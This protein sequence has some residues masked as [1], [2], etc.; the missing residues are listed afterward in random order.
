VKGTPKKARE[1][2]PAA[3]S[4]EKSKAAPLVGLASSISLLFFL[5]VCI[6][7]EPVDSISVPEPTEQKKK[8]VI[9]TKAKA[10]AISSVGV[11]CK[12]CVVFKIFMCTRNLPCL[13]TSLAP[14]RDLANL[15][16]I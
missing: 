15:L 7:E 11:P 1:S 13:T 14:L 5:S 8:V 2:K 12:P 3:K 4:K 9:K 10:K 16:R 6:Q